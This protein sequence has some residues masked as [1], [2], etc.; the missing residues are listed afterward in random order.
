MTSNAPFLVQAARA[1]TRSSAGRTFTA[2]LALHRL[3]HER[4]RIAV[5]CAFDRADF[6]G[7]ERRVVQQAGVRSAGG[8][9]PGHRECAQ[10]APVEAALKGDGAVPAGCECREF[11]GALDGFRAAVAE[12]DPVEMS[13]QCRSECLDVV[14][15]SLARDVQGTEGEPIGLLPDRRDDRRVVVTQ[16]ADAVPG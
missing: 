6:G 4:G 13:R 16:A 2:A 14:R 7:Y 12:K 1:A 9:I 3:E 11:Q 15:P 8:G 10:G 5:D